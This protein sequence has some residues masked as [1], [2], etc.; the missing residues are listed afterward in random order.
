MGTGKTRGAHGRWSLRVRESTV[1]IAACLS[2][3]L[4]TDQGA[5]AK[6]LS[7]SLVIMD[8]AGVRIVTNPTGALDAVTPWQVGRVPLVTIGQADGA[9]ENLLY[10]VVGGA[11]LSNG[12]IVI[13]NSGTAELRLYDPRGLHLRSAGRVGDGPGEFRVL[14]WAGVFRGDSIMVVDS[15]LS[16][17][18]IYDEHLTFVRL[19]SFSQGFGANPEPLG[20][21]ND[22]RMLAHPRVSTGEPPPDSVWNE[23]TQRRRYPLQLAG[24]DGSV[25][26]VLGDVLDTEWFRSSDG[27]MVEVVFGHRFHASAAGELIAVGDDATNSF[28]VHDSVGRLS[29]IVR[30]RHRPLRV[31]DT[32][33][34]EAIAERE[35]RSG[36]RPRI[37]A[38]LRAAP[39]P[40]YYPAFRSLRLD[41]LGRVWVQQYRAPTELRPLWMVYDS[42]GLLIG[43]A[44]LPEGHELLDASE[45]GLLTR[46][47]D[48]QG[49][50]Q[51]HVL[52]LS[53]S[54]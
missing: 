38:A 52:Q 21:L 18:S 46:T 44:E 43:R 40:Q 27:A 31:G 11:I 20:V 3:C 34:A 51:V 19:L 16:R 13:A 15:Q 28:S 17:G 33:Y 5:I 14:R 49:V 12:S 22:G 6:Q 39:R 32:D 30:Q 26:R 4:Q 1:I 48:T 24:G 25:A 47:R 35:R 42:N 9:D 10:E 23:R 37:S 7:D 29:L 53:G 41:G 50:E 8:S 36:F 2:G 45:A 54:R